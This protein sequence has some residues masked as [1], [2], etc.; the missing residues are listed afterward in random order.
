LQTNAK[1]HKIVQLDENG[2]PNFRQKSQEVCGRARFDSVL[3]RRGRRLQGGAAHERT[4][5]AGETRRARD[6]QT[7]QATG[8]GGAMSASE[9][10]IPKEDEERSEPQVD[11]VG[12]DKWAPRFGLLIVVLSSLVLW[13]GIFLLVAWIF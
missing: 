5:R 7:D 12:E 9:F 10:P 13:S 6:P 3:S 11:G 2:R 1:F 8:P 4:T